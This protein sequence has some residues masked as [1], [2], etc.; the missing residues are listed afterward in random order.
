MRGSSSGPRPLC[1]IPLAQ[2]ADALRK[3]DFRL[4]AQQG[5]G[6]ID[7]RPGGHH[8]GRVNPGRAPSLSAHSQ[9]GNTRTVPVGCS[10]DSRPLNVITVL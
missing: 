4:P 2:A 3:V 10:I 9:A 5:P 1:A 6:L 8:I 7:V